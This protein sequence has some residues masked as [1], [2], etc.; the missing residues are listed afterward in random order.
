MDIKYRLANQKDIDSLI[1]L[2][3][4]LDEYICKRDGIVTQSTSIL[5]ENMK[6][7]LQK[8]LNKSMYFFLAIDTKHDQVVAGGCIIIHTM[9]PG[10]YFIN[11]IKGY[12]TGVYTDENYRKL[13][14]QRQIIS[15]LLELGRERKCQRIEL[16]AINPHAISLYRSFGFQKANNKF[17]IDIKEGIE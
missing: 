11:G 5:K 8:E 6:K 15:M 10:V 12:I 7:V 3:L 9:L 14:I 1:N 2:R 4:K 13:G 17:I 16:D